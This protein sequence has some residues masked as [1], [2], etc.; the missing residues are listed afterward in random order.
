MLK[1][2]LWRGMRLSL[3]K[4][5]SSGLTKKRTIPANGVQYLAGESQLVKNSEDVELR[6]I[7][8]KGRSNDLPTMLFFPDLFDSA[9]NW[10]SYFLHAPHSVLDYRDVYI[11]Y[12]RNFGSSDWCNEV[13]AE[14]ASDIA[15]D[16]ERFMYTHKLTMA[17][18]AGHGFGAKNAMVTACYKPNLVTGVLA[19]DYAPQD[20]TYFRAPKAYKEAMKSV[21]D[22]VGLSRMSHERFSDHLE[23]LIHNPKIRTLIQQNFILKKG[24]QRGMKFNIDFAHHRFDDLINWKSVYGIFGGRTKFLFPEFSEFVF[25]NS[26][27]LS[28]MKVCTQNNGFDEDINTLACGEND[29]PEVNHW[30]Y[31]QPDLIHQASFRTCEFL[32]KFD[33]VHVLLKNRAELVERIPIPSIRGERSDNY[34]GL[35]VPAHLHHNWRFNENPSLK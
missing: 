35:Y 7:K 32:Q 13:P 8:L 2:S 30:I 25:L 4:R 17:T 18:L 15:D 1:S 31:E 19:Y 12:P 28:M 10:V 5:F 34:S 33:G 26:N 24:G 9:E 22:L 27:T 16:V 3:D 11:I 23:D 6:G 29:N 20:Y 21:K 14:P